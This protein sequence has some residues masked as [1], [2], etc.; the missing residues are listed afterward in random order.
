MSFK[1]SISLFFRRKKVTVFLLFLVLALLFSILTK[2]SEDYTKTIT[3]KIKPIHIPEDKLIIQDSSHLLK[4]DLRTYGFKL[5]RYY[6]KKPTVNINIENLDKDDKHYL[7]TEKKAFSEIV[8]QFDPNVIIENINPDTLIFRY[9]TNSVKSVPIVL[10]KEIDF[11]LG[12]NVVGAY[13][14]EPDSIRIIGPGVLIDTIN[15]IATNRITLSDVNSDISSTIALDLLTNKQIR[16]SHDKVKFEAKVDKFTE[17]TVEV[18]VIVKNIPDNIKI[19]IF[20]KTVPVVF[21]SSLSDFKA[22][23]NNNFIVECDYNTMELN[24]TYLVPKLIQKPEQIKNAKLS[25][26]KIEFIITQ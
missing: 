14:I 13:S 24:R 7:W 4:V 15:S 11:S 8:A 26:N 23:S 6:F 12:F 1:Q 19:N 16:F 25:V 21:Y 3:F 18:P 2:L 9:D 5:L 10:N 17:G 20:P 22:I